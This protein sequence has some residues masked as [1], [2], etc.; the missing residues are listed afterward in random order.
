MDRKDA[1]FGSADQI[2][3]GLADMATPR[4]GMG[5]VTA[6]DSIH[7]IGGA[8]QAGFGVTDV[9]EVFRP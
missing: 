2:G 4:H 9:H 5:A 3:P 7:V 6:G 1:W 8:V